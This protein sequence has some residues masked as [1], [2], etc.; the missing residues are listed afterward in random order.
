[1]QYSLSTGSSWLFRNL[2]TAV[3]QL[4]ALAGLSLTVTVLPLQATVDKE[5]VKKVTSL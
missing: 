1:M 5:A 2:A 3:L 4:M